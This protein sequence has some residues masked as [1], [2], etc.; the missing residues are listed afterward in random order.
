MV[1][2]TKHFHLVGLTVLIVKDPGF[3]ESCSFIFFNH[4][5]KK[6]GT[7]KHNRKKGMILS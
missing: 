4:L 2:V 7:K 3:P 6:Q 5:L 1:G